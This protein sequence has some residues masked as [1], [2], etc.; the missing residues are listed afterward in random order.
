VIAMTRTRAA[1]HEDR[2]VRMLWAVAALFACL[3]L[4]SCTPLPGLQHG[5]G[6]A[7]SGAG[8]TTAT[9]AG[10][11]SGGTKASV[12]PPLPE[13]YPVN[14]PY[15]M[16]KNAGFEQGLAGWTVINQPG[17]RDPGNNIVETATWQERNGKVLHITRTSKQDGGASGVLQTPNVVVTGAKRVSVTYWGYV[18]YEAGGNIA[19][20]NPAWYPEGG[21]QVRVKYVDTTGVQREYYHGL[22]MTPTGGADTASFTKVAD[23]QWYKFVSPNLMDLPDKPARITEVRFYGF[24]WGFDAMFDDAQLIVVR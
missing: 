6:G 22:Y 14:S 16:L 9:S 8:G 1:T 2:L 12:P 13:D 4:T 24:G 7:T 5:G 19:N 18:N 15:G 17:S 3:L 23:N 10:T 11:A 20:H 21:A